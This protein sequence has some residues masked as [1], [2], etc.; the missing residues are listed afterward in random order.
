MRTDPLRRLG[1]LTVLLAFLA[2]GTIRPAGAQEPGRRIAMVRISAPTEAQLRSIAGRGI[3]VHAGLF[4]REAVLFVTEE[5]LQAL[6]DAGLAPQVIEPDAAAFFASRM[7]ASAGPGSMGGYYTLS[8][9]EARLDELASRYP[10]IIT[11]KFSV[12]TSVEGRDVWAVRVSDAPGTPDPARPAVFYNALIHAREPMSMMLLMGFLEDLAGKWEEGDEGIRYLLSSRE[13]WF[14]PVVNPDGYHYNEVMQPEGGYLWRKNKRDNN[15][16]GIFREA[17]DGVD[18]NRNFGYEW[19]HDDVGSSPIPGSQTYRGA[20]PFSEPETRAV[21]DVVQGAGLS[22]PPGWTFVLNYHSYAN[23]YI[24]PWG[25]TESPPARLDEFQRWAGRLS[26]TNFFPYGTGTAMIGYQT[27]G[28]AVDWQYGAEDLLAMVPEVGS[29]FDYFWPASVRIPV[30]TREQLPANHLTAWM[31]GGLLLPDGQQVAEVGG[32]GDGYPDPGETFELTLTW[33]NAGFTRAVTGASAALRSLDGAATVPGT[34]VTLGDLAPGESM[35]A[36]S[37][38]P[39]TVDASPGGRRLSF[40]VRVEAD[41]GYVRRDTLHVMLGVPDV[42]VEE[43]W[44]TEGGPWD[45]AGGF[46]RSTEGAFSGMY[47]AFD[48]ALGGRGAVNYFD[49]TLPVDLS[50]YDGARLRFKSRRYVGPRNAAFLT[51]GPEPD[52]WPGQQTARS[53]DPL[54]Y[55]ATGNGEGWEDVVIDLTPYSGTPSLWLRWATGYVST[56]SAPSPQGWAVDD[57]VLEAW[58]E[59]DPTGGGEVAGSLH[60]GMPYPN[61]ANPGP[62]NPVRLDADLSELGQGLVSVRLEV[63]DVRGRRVATPFRGTLESRDY[64]GYLTW[65]GS[66]S[67]GEPAPSGI[68]I[69]RLSAAGQSA[70]RKVIILR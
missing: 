38:Y 21:R 45:L 41:G 34:A 23:V 1:R 8:E 4:A 61:P 48:G 52:P 25:Y 7:D 20:S 66:L 5:E 46:M 2:A 56:V 37:A 15:G 16:D 59:A 18:L 49:R 28:D 3:E 68:Y 32:D 55:Y 42:L 51:L 57:I 40:E 30:I 33:T 31:A 27:N 29:L 26:G 65:D 62:G 11:P 6:R 12:G 9:V 22:Q 14:V 47:G 43:G 50:G 54:V 19:G 53:P 17:D 67:G 35:Q 69:L 70:S 10:D 39:V 13:L 60:L 24:H 58:T 44:E 64:S 63:Y 36:P